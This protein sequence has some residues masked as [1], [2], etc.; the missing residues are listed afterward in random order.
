MQKTTIH[1]SDSSNG[2][3]FSTTYAMFEE[4]NGNEASCNCLHE[5][6]SA[7]QMSLFFDYLYILI[8]SSLE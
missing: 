5:E 1:I 4:M 2:C 3:V 8:Q 7:Q 6:W